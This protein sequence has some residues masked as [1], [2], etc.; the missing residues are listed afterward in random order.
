[1]TPEQGSAP[2]TMDETPVAPAEAASAPIALQ[3]NEG[4]KL[5]PVEETAVVPEQAP[6]AP[7]AEAEA[8]Q[9]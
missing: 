6:A 8:P 7:A 9:D 2:L 3:M 1:M 4:G 5:E